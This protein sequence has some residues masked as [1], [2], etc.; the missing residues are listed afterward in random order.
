MSARFGRG[1]G[2]HTENLHKILKSML[3]ARVEDD[4]QSWVY[5]RVAPA[6]G[7]VES[8]EPVTVT[9]ETE[10]VIGVEARDEIF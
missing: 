8:V 7:E 4:P 1:N 2:H 6:G 9:G 10:G 5:E 3:K